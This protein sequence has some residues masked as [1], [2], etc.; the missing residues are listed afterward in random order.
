MQSLGQGYMFTKG[1]SLVLN[2]IS[3]ENSQGVK[4]RDEI[5]LLNLEAVPG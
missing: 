1:L 2:L 5:L 3:K 4:Q